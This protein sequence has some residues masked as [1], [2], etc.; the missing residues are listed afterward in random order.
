MVGPGLPCFEVV[1]VRWMGFGE[2]LQS[3]VG[4]VG[5][6]LRVI[7]RRTTLQSRSAM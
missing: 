1:G 7:C 2:G 6:V 4:S 5:S 3:V